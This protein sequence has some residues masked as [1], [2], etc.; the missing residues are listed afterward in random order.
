M[1]GRITKLVKGKN[2]GQA[3]VAI[4]ELV[5]IPLARVFGVPGIKA[6]AVIPEEVM[7]I[8]RIIKASGFG[9]LRCGSGE[10]VWMMVSNNVSRKDGLM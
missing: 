3:G 4:G 10:V 6:R 5:L 2:N 7:V 1:P 8:P 9:R